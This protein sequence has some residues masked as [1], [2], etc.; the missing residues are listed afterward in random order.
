MQTTPAR[1]VVFRCDPEHQSV[2]RHFVESRCRFTFQGIPLGPRTNSSCSAGDGVAASELADQG[3]DDGAEER[4]RLGV[5]RGEDE[6]RNP[7]VAV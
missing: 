7:V 6:G 5:V 1:T 4:D 2:H 3:R